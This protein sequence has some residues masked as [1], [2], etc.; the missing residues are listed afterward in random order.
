VSRAVRAS[1]RAKIAVTDDVFDRLYPEHVQRMSRVHW[2]PVAVALRVAAWLAPEPGMRVLDLG[3]G[4][5][6]Q[7]CIGALAS[8]AIW[9]G[10]EIDPIL[11][12]AANAAATAL[13]VDDRALFT[14]GEMASVDWAGFAGLYVYNPFEAAMFWKPFGKD[15]AA[16]LAEEIAE[17]AQ[18]LAEL[19]TGMRV[20]TYHGFGGDM[21]GSYA[22]VSTEA[23]GTD[24]LTLWIKRSTSS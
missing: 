20:V 21:P 17:T 3:A 13:G 11:V 15:A 8:D 7:C 14:V 19:P 1:L 9:H 2:T 24:H 10:I 16:R 6:K 23:N 12:D 22:R 4:P 18:R 5:G